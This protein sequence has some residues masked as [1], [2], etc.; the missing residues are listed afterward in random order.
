MATGSLDANGIWIYGEDDS[1]ATFSGLLNKLGDSVSDKFSSGRLLK[2]NLPSGTVLQVVQHST[3]GLT[4]VT[5]TTFQDTVLTGAITPSSASSKVL[6][7]AS[8]TLEII[9]V[10]GLTYHTI[11]RGNAATGTNLG[12]ATS[13]LG[14]NGF[15]S[16]ASEAHRANVSLQIL[17]A[18]NTTS[19]QTYTV[20]IRL[21]N[22][23]ST[24]LGGADVKNTLTL[25]EVAG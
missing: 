18:P 19:A 20:A 6:V 1:E 17:D 24:T 8:F 2:A 5:A 21:N 10:S 22:G 25:I 14:R 13:G 4:T 23:T 15:A 7:L 11:F 3:T 16:T 12:N 9:G